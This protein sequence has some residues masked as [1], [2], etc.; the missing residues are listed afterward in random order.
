M[1]VPKF[2]QRWRFFPDRQGRLRW[3]VSGLA[4]AL[5]LFTTAPLLAQQTGQVT[6]TVVSALNGLPLG[7]VQVSIPGTGLGQLTNQDGRFLLLNVPLGEHEVVAQLIGYGEERSTVNVTAG[8]PVVVDFSLRTRAVELEGMVV[9]GTPIAAQRREVG[10]S[11]SLITA[12]QIEA[13]P[14][15][16]VQDILRGRTLGVTVTG[17]PSQPGAGQNLT[18]R[19]LNSLNGRN[20]PLIYID[21]V[22]MFE[23]QYET[24]NS[25][26]QGATSLGGIDVRDIE[27]IEVIKGAAASTLYGSEAAAGVIQIFTKRGRAGRPRWTFNMDQSVTHIGHVGP[28]SDPTG[29]QINKCNVR[30]PFW[31]D[32]VPLDPTCPESGSW[33]K[34]GWGQRYDLNVRGGSEDLTYYLSSGFSDESGNV[35]APMGGAQSYNLRANFQFDG[36]ENFQIRFNSSYNRRDIEWIPNGDS[37]EGL[38]RNVATLYEDETD[39]EDG[40]VFDKT[41]DQFINHFN[42]SGNL[43]WTPM[44]NFRH[45]LNVGVDWSNSHYV[46]MRPWQYFQYDIGQRTLDIEDN[47]TITVDYATS[48]SS[49]IPFLNSDFTSV[50]SGGGQYAA[51]ERLGNRTDVEGFIGPGAKVL[52]NAETA[53]NYN[54]DYDGT[55]SGGFFVQEQLGWK[56]RLFLTAGFRADSHSNF[57]DDLDHKYFFLIYPKVQATYTLSD[58]SFW[59]SWWETSRIRAAY[60]ESGEPPRPGE[61]LV[62]WQ[63]SSLADENALGFIIQNQGNPEIGPERTRE[64]EVGL[65]G[66]FL[67]GKVNYTATAYTRETYDGLVS[68]APPPSN[69]IAENLFQNIGNWEAKGFEAALDL[70]VYD[71]LDV[72]VSM[73]SRYQW[74]ETKMIRLS[75]REDATYNLD[76]NQSFR[77]GVPMPSSFQQTL[78]NGDS[79]GVLPVYSDTTEYQG[80]SYPPHEA[81]AGV[82]TT[83]WNRLTLDAFA[84]AQWGHVLYD[85]LAQEIQGDYGGFWEPCKEINDQVNAWYED[86]NVGT[87]AGLTAREIAQCSE[88]F[89]NN[90][91]WVNPGDYI[92]L[93]TAN[94]SYRLPE[95]WLERLPGSFEQATIQLQ[96][97]NL[98]LWTRFRGVHP[99]ALINT[100]A[101]VDRSAGY[102]LPPPRR[103]TLNLRLNF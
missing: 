28:E 85:D 82:T 26:S 5:A 57:G 39:N 73:N 94:I 50:L 6:G 21:G 36:F 18:I 11:I 67:L 84:F 58:H 27:R 51:V 13:L 68:I 72:Q 89:S 70:L 41:E 15:T 52:E 100:A 14:V 101:T 9:T 4:V 103:F 102:I 54:E 32:S 64:Y 22:R 10:N 59:P 44:D 71:G 33:L 75:N 63:A 30:G 88:N 66:S 35:N 48:Y 91:D 65:D 99:D 90:R 83:F 95:E 56:N 3:L 96:G 16:N 93:G 76:Y 19:G 25:N 7:D 81:S 61:S 37:W 17:S 87:L 24:G 55:K 49:G 80:P 78:L 2:S 8:A 1:S 69:G 98:F 47:R 29:L 92:R 79:V 62:Y 60:G 20:E 34:T 42:F 53:Y 12:E 74:N 77:I 46:T 38:M 43:N 97:Q 40:K 31:P 86:P 45:R 23:G